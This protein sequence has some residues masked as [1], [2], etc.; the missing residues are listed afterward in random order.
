M[1][2]ALELCWDATRHDAISILM[3]KARFWYACARGYLECG[4]NKLAVE[5]QFRGR[6]ASFCART[7]MGVEH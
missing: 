1:Y 5:C 6:Q 4:E 7:L 2:E 3:D